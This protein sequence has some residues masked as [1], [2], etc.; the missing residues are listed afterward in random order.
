[1]VWPDIAKFRHFGKI[2]K[3]FGH[4]CGMSYYFNQILKL[5]W[6]ISNGIRQIFIVVNG[7]TLK[8]QFSHLVTLS[9]ADGVKHL[10]MTEAKSTKCHAL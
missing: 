3:V 5:L 4:F 9:M 6:N 1:M 8:K 2:L 10:G 7:P